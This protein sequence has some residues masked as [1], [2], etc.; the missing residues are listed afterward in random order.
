MTAAHLIGTHV[1]RA[2]ARH[3]GIEPL[4]RLVAA[5]LPA[6]ERGPWLQMADALV[7]GDVTKG[8]AAATA[9][10][11]CWIPLFA[12]TENDRRLAVRLLQTA[13]RPPVG[14]ASVWWLVSYP[15]SL[16]MVALAVLAL[17]VFLV[18]PEFESIFSAFGVGLPLVTQI[19]IGLP[20]L[21][22]RVWPPI[23]V[24]GAVVAMAWWLAI[25]WSASSATAV[26]NF[27]RSLARL[28]AAEIPTDEA[29]ALAGHA[30]GAAGLDL[31]SPRRPLT[32]A[33]A[34]A[35]DFAPRPAAVLLDAIAD[36]HDDRSR[37]RLDVT[38]W[39]FGPALIG[40]VG[41]IVSFLTLAL[42]M[43]LIKLVFD[44]S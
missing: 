15:L 35:L 9:S 39:F 33:A 4:V 44:L 13:A 18:L 3:R 10:M 32:Y 17:V 36:C 26:A 21:I 31:A 2:L 27:T 6:G 7:T 11:A 37:G 1:T 25:R 28:V 42:F 12:S 16:A 41:L 20:S 29:L 30:A 19:A 24:T 23:L 5:E 34:A 14:I 22:M 43:P 40:V 8:T 38:A